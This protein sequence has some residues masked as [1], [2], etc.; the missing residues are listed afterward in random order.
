MALTIKTERI[1]EMMAEEAVAAAKLDA[2]VSKMNASTGESKVE[3]IAELL[4]A[5]VQQHKSMRAHDGQSGHDADARGDEE[6]EGRR[7]VAYGANT[8]QR[9]VKTRGTGALAVRFRGRRTS[10]EGRSAA[11]SVRLAEHDRSMRVGLNA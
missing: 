5:L 3:A 10:S 7:Q 8:T 11:P 2:L 4:T 9:A 6:E 1:G